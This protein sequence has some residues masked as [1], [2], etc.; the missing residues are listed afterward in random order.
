MTAAVVSLLL[1]QLPDLAALPDVESVRTVRACDSPRLTILHVRDWHFIDFAT[2][3]ADVA[4]QVPEDQVAAQYVAFAREVQAIQD[5]QERALR[6]LAAAGYQ[7][8]WIEGLTPEEEP[9]LSSICRVAARNGLFETPNPLHVGAA[10]RLF[11]ERV[12]RVHALDTEEGLRLANPV[13]KDGNLRKVSENDFEKRESLMMK[14][15]SE[16]NGAAII[17]LGGGH[18]LSNNVTD[19]VRLIEVTVTGYRDASGEKQ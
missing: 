14:Q 17:I 7:D 12:I 1:A 6:A 10:G 13:D 2:F 16:Q 3:A 5:R 9:K 4:G 8:V 18:D 11:V 15:L 19:D